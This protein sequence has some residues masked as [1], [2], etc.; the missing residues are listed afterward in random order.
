MPRPAPDTSTTWP[1]NKPSRN[2]S[3]MVANSSSVLPNFSLMSPLSLWSCGWQA[4]QR[5]PQ[6]TRHRDGIVHQHLGERFALRIDA[7]R[8]DAAAAERVVQ[9]EIERLDAGEIVALDF[10]HAIMGEPIADDVFHQR[11]AQPRQIFALACDQADIGG[12]ALV[13]AATNCQSD[14]RHLG[15]RNAN[16]FWRRLYRRRRR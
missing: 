11:S 5:L 2:V 14:Q 10:A 6:G 1:A 13:T 3:G 9:H 7:K 12:I 15:V 8:G 16:R 4:R